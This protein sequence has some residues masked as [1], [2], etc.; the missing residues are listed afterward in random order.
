MTKEE[1]PHQDPEELESFLRGWAGGAVGPVLDW[2]LLY[3]EPYCCRSLRS[4]R[5]RT[6]WSVVPTPNV[7]VPSPDYG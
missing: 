1:L 5:A 3:E 4:G 2:P 7:R 6:Q